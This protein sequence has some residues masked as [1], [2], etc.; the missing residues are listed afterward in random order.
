MSRTGHRKR[1]RVVGRIVV[2]VAVGVLAISM[3]GRLVG[4]AEEPGATV[5]SPPMPTGSSRTTNP[6]PSS[7]AASSPAG[8]TPAAETGLVV[9]AVVDGDTVRVRPAG[10]DTVQRVRL[11][12]IDAPETGTCEAAAATT[13]LEMLVLN[14]S[15]TLTMGG[16]GEDLD[17]YGRALRYVD[18]TDGDAGL[19][20]LNGGHVIA[21]YDSR[22]G[23]GRHDLED[24]YIA[25]DAASPALACSV[26]PSTITELPPTPVA[27]LVGADAD[28]THP[29][30]GPTTT[31]R[32]PDAASYPNCTA[33]RAAG[34][35]PLYAGAPGYSAE[36]DRD[37]DGVA[38]E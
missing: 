22:D 28:R 7:A 20:L 12:G 32:D 15:V 11:I 9:V 19:A 5:P 26:G 17:P 13:A 38:C 33:A 25:A 27:P 24:N 1:G 29:D 30:S 37:G 35:A 36:L 4:G 2:G 16:D 8:S 6:I 21:R 23:Y 3:F 31:S 18:T 10:S 34:A 14:R